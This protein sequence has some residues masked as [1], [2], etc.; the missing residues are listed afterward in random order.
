L[1]AAGTALGGTIISSTASNNNN[2]L[3]KVLPG[4][5]VAM[6][7]VKEAVAPPKNQE[8]NTTTQIRSVIKRLEYL[9]VDNALVGDRDPD[10]A[11]KIKRMKDELKQA[12]LQLIDIPLFENDTDESN[13]SVND[14]FNDPKVNKKYKTIRK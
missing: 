6:V 1:T 12:Q 3:G 10:V 9:Q 8:Q 2:N 13:R 4:I 14:Y 7:P 5:G 11:A